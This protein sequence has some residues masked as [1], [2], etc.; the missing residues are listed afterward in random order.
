MVSDGWLAA[1]AG[2]G[3]CLRVGLPA[4]PAGQPTPTFLQLPLCICI[5][6]HVYICTSAYSYL[7]LYIT[8]VWLC[9]LCKMQ[10]A[11]KCKKGLCYFGKKHSALLRQAWTSWRNYTFLLV[12]K[13]MSSMCQT[14][15]LG[16]LGYRFKRE[17]S[18]ICIDL[19]ARSDKEKTSNQIS[20]LQKTH[21]TARK[22]LSCKCSS[23]VFQ[24]F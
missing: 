11:T 16:N 23:I 22:L 15:C 3:T 4:R 12:W 9:I 14:T 10:C 6:T 19:L 1:R 20:T 13:S 17:R 18:L 21:C 8:G 2:P 7:H 5:C 24:L